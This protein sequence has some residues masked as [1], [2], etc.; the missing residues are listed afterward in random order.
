MYCF[1][2]ENKETNWKQRRRILKMSIFSELHEIWTQIG[3]V[4][5]V[6]FGQSLRPVTLM[7]FWP[8]VK[9]W[10]QGW[11]KEILYS[12]YK[13]Q[14]NALRVI[15]VRWKMFFYTYHIQSTCLLQSQSYFNFFQ[16]QMS[17]VQ[18]K[19]CLIFK[20]KL[21]FHTLTFICLLTSQSG[22]TKNVQ[23]FL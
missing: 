17:F 5:Y 23:T 19:I 1:F 7:C 11:R 21:Y 14:L 16:P 3:I 20:H 12:L 4:F 2:T 13:L 6:S 8:I 15:Y 10:F 22:I 18:F 9:V